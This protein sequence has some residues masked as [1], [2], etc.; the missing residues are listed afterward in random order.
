MYYDIILSFSSP[1]L[2]L[3]SL[4]SLSILLRMKNVNNLNV[5]NWT[6]NTNWYNFCKYHIIHHVCESGRC[7]CGDGFSKH[8]TTKKLSLLE[9]NHSEFITIVYLSS[10]I[11][12]GV[13]NF[14]CIISFKK[15]PARGSSF[16]RFL[17]YVTYGVSL[18]ILFSV[19]S[20]NHP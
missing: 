15:A 16:I 17:V 6:R 9:E 10:A 8:L 11:A 4:S 19:I 12:G 7:S 1:F 13:Q 3:L 2:V 20:L 14:W 5:A 18:V